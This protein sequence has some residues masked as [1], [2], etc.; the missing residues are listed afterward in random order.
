MLRPCL[1]GAGVHEQ[2]SAGI[3]RLLPD[4]PK[5]ATDATL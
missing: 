2:Q 3:D 4:L 5:G 1:S